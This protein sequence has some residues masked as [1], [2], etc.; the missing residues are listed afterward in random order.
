MSIHHVIVGGGPVATNAIETIRQFDNGTSQITLIC[1]EPAHSRMALPYWLAGQI[2]RGHTHTADDAYFERL[3]VAPRIGERVARTDA[4]HKSVQLESGETIPFDNLLIATGSAPARP[5]ISGIDLPGVQTLWTLE[6]TAQLLAR[7]GTETPRVLMVGAGFIGFIMLN[8]MYKRDW[9]LA[10]V[11]RE[12]Q[13]LPRMLD[14]AGGALVRTWLTAKGVDLHTGR[15]VQ[16]ISEMSDGA[17]Q[18]ELDNGQTLQA[19]IVVIAT[20]IQPNLSLVEGSGI[21]ID[22]GI[23]V[24]DRMR[25]NA[26]H[27]YAGGDVAQGPVLYGDGPAI[28]A[29]QP[30]AV[31]HGRVAG[32]QMAGQDIRYPG[33]LLMNVLDTCGLQCASFGAWH[34]KDDTTVIS[35]PI[36]NI[37]RNLVWDGDQLIGASFIGRAGDMGMLNDVGMVKGILQTQTPLGEW[38][39]FLQENPFDIRRA[40]IANKVAARL[41]G[42]TLLGRP[43]QPRG[44]RFANTP[45]KNEA[46]KSHQVYVAPQ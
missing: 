14:V 35:N 7:A 23:L 43:S 42:T 9:K 19:D 21:K 39:A 4:L 2:P 32:A 25:T 11:E 6:D 27:V 33:S 12:P 10:V 24:D 28:H 30:T 37:Y 29:I 16:A 34:V 13:V 26:P 20:G 8:A 40:Y 1:D 18:I 36:S 46:T 17:K 41:A 5:P 45:V 3:G 15:T 44:F 22:A 31:D 38:K